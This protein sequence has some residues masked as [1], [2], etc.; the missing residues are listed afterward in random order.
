MKVLVNGGLNLSELDGWWAEA[1][2]PDVGWALGDGLD[3][4]DGPAR[5]DVE[6]HALYDLLETAVIPEFYDRSETGIPVAWIKR[7]RESMARLTPRFSANRAVREYTEGHYL[8][9]ASAYRERALGK[10]AVG[11]Q[12]VA[13][14]H[15]LDQ[16]WDSLHFGGVRVNTQPDWQEV[17][18]E[19]FLNGVDPDAV[20]VQLYAEALNGGDPISLAMAPV[21]APPDASQPHVYRVA[22]SSSRPVSDY[23]ARAIPRNTHAAVPLECARIAWQR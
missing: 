10:G 21:H 8:P 4:G 23:T 14:R 11:R 15:A 13:W 19:L 5:D 16:H 6:A 7:M 2:T 1:F 20:Q 12:L 22:L 9:A 17:E 3:H 18:V